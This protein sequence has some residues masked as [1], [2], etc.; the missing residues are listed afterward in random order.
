M[1]LTIQE[2]EHIAELA[3][4]DLSDEEKELFR[5]QLSSILD[6][7]AMLQGVETGDIPPTASVLPERSVLRQDVVQEPLKPET[8]LQNVFAAH[9]KEQQFKVPLVMGNGQ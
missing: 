3:K 5:E 7:A 9:Q 8:V 1:Q 4:L 2:V 6:Y